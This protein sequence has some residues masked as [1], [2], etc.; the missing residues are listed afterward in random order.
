MCIFI[1][2]IIASVSTPCNHYNIDHHK[3]EFS[4]INSANSFLNFILEEKLLTLELIDTDATFVLFFVV[5][6]IMQWTNFSFYFSIF[7]LV[8]HKSSSS[9][10]KRRKKFMN[11]VYKTF[12]F[13]FPSTT[14]EKVH[15]FH[16]FGEKNLRACNSSSYSLTID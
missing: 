1:R 4:N 6:F 3:Y 5:F 16:F 10:K 8:W 11:G 12:P 15:K 13:I 7:F 2:C 9:R 14:E